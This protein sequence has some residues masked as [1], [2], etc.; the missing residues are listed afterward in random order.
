MFPRTKLGLSLS[1]AVGRRRWTQRAGVWSIALLLHNLLAAHCE[2]W[3]REFRVTFDL[4]KYRSRIRSGR[5]YLFHLLSGIST[6]VVRPDSDLTTQTKPV[7]SHPDLDVGPI[8]LWHPLKTA[9]V[10][11]GPRGQKTILSGC[12]TNTYFGVSDA[13]PSVLAIFAILLDLVS[14]HPAR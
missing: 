13:I 1:S 3:E 4:H 2:R 5:L 11:D 9:S 10:H 14:N 8:L 12:D 7:C 6:S